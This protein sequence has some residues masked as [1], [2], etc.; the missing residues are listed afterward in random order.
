[1]LS[2]PALTRLFW[3][4]MQFRYLGDR[5]SFQR[6]VARPVRAALSADGDGRATVTGL[7]EL[8]KLHRQVLPFVLRREK[9]EVL[10]DLPPKIVTD[11]LCDLTPEQRRLHEMW[12]RG[13]EDA[14]QDRRCRRCGIVCSS[15]N[16]Q[17]KICVWCR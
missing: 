3:C 16:C 15:F 5:R 12:E 4:G 14:T 7:K 8:E 6:D 9:V 13:G 2:P 11:L 10:A 17:R 1:M